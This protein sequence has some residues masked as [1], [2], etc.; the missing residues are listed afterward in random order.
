MGSTLFLG[1]EGLFVCHAVGDQREADSDNSFS[2]EV[3][4][5]DFLFFVIDNFVFFCGFKLSRHKSKSNV[6][7]ESLF[8][9]AIYVEESF[10][11][12]ENVGK[13][14]NCHDLVFK[15]A[16]QSFQVLIFV[17]ET[18]ESILSPKV[19]EVI[20]NLS[21]QGLRQRDVVCKSG[22]ENQPVV[23]VT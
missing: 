23:Q 21:S 19:I 4:F 11:Q 6:I 7:Q 17:V 15:F 22:E 8:L 20:F 3:H 18:S 13:E 5:R 2:D 9:D 14:V 1:D 10:E 12:L 16:G